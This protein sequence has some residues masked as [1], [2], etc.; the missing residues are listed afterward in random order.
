M[1]GCCMAG[2]W[3][4]LPH[5][6]PHGHAAVCCGTSTLILLS[7]SHC[8]AEGVT[9]Y[10]A[11]VSPKHLPLPPCCWPLFAVHNHLSVCCRWLELKWFQYE[12][13]FGVFIFD[14]R[15]KVVVHLVLLLFIVLINWGLYKQVQNLHLN[16]TAWGHY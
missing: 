1:S 13:T 9:L 2:R 6:P 7:S 5:D 3:L 8:C 16:K 11:T 4:L 14:S 10:A 12:I 15:E